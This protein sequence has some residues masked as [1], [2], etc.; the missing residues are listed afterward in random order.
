M[1]AAGSVPANSFHPK[2]SLNESGM[3]FTITNQ[4]S[5]QMQTMN[6]PAEKHADGITI[7]NQATAEMKEM[8]DPSKFL[9]EDFLSILNEHRKNCERE[10]KFDQ[11]REAR[12]RLKEL[13]IFE[14]EKTK[15]DT[16]AK[17]RREIVALENAHKVELK[18]LTNKWNNII[19]PQN[20]NEAALIEMELKKRQ[21]KELDAFRISIETGSCQQGRIHYSTRILE[22]TKKAEYLGST[23][24][25]KDAKQLKKE[26]K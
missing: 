8:F 11:A 21:Q 20:E 19:L 23:G 12:K 13:R 9:S 1:R 5:R 15:Q 6:P 14:E 22:A 7:E 25:Y 3:A 4:K 26:I 10:G 2:P 17:H 24:F 16:F 18:E